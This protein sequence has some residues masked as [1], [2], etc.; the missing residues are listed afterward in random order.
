MIQRLAHLD[1]DTVKSIFRVARFNLMDQKQVKRLRAAA[2]QN[3]D[4][5]AL[6][7]WTNVFMK[8]IEEI[9]TATN[10]KSN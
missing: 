8:R 6:D 3:V 1:R 10:C 2:S 5:A 7:E 9:R 4:E